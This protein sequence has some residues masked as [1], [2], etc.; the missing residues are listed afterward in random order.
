MDISTNSNNSDITNL[1]ENAEVVS[2]DIFDTLIVRPYAQP[3]DLF[4]HLE[5]LYNKKDFAERRVTAEQQARVK[6]PDKEDVTLEQIYEELGSDFSECK[7]L[8][9][10][11]EK[12]VLKAIPKTKEIFERAKSIGKRVVITS[13]VYLPREF[14]A[15]ILNDNGYTGYE[16]LYVSS[17]LML[18]KHFGT[19]FAYII[20]D[21]NVSPE[22]ILHI[23]D[24]QHADIFMAGQH[25]IKTFHCP[26]AIDLLFEANPKASIFYQVHN[27]LEASILLGLIALSYI[28]ADNA[29]A[30]SDQYGRYWHGFGYQYGG[31]VILAFTKWLDDCFKRDGIKNALFIARDGYTLQKVYDIV[32]TS[33]AASHYCYAPRRHSIGCRL[34]YADQLA[35]GESSGQDAVKAI[36]SFYKNKIDL[37]GIN[38]PNITSAEEGH[39]FIQDHIEVYKQIAVHEIQ[40]YKNYINSLLSSN[41]EIFDSTSNSHPSIGLVDSIGCFLSAQ[42]LITAAIGRGNLN[43]YYWQNTLANKDDANT[44]NLN[45]FNPTGANSFYDWNIMELIMTAPTPPIADFTGDSP[46]YKKNI[47]EEEKARI[48]VY[49]YISDGSVDFAKRAKL[50]FGDLDLFLSSNIMTDWINIFL[51][52]PS[53]E[54]MQMFETIQHAYDANHTEYAPILN[55]ALYTQEDESESAIK[56]SIIV[57]VYNSDKYL[58]FCLGSLIVQTLRDIE[59]IC[60]NDGST[61]NSQK[62]L[63]SYAQIDPRIK[64]I[65]QNNAG[66]SSARNTGMAAATGTYLAFVDSDD[67]VAIDYFEKLRTTAR[68]SGAPVACCKSIVN[69]SS[70]DGKEKPETLT[71]PLPAPGVYSMSRRLL[72]SRTIFSSSCSKLYKRSLIEK[73]NLKFPDTPTHQ[74]LYFHWC[75]LPQLSKLAVAEGTFYFSLQR[76]DSVSKKLLNASS[77][78]SLQVFDLI[79]NY[80]KDHDLLQ[81]FR[82]PFYILQESLNSCNN[83]PEF[84]AS[85]NALWQKVHSEIS[86][87]NIYNN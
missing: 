80:Y 42:K 70:G 75:L 9:L 87:A 47:S 13:D 35:A 12:Q 31:P 25:G 67:Y 21:L 69:I 83:D 86:Q 29:K 5:K 64:I 41:N 2:F 33:E 16:K 82:L 10:A 1:L 3:T 52:N 84:L 36:L 57:P 34:D 51:A 28:E 26:K 37:L 77:A 53:L 79:F 48:E 81:K 44:Y 49:P 7:D 20:K 62:I 55:P 68:L 38:T 76:E 23:G 14:L 72:E 85:A 54:D 6:R 61:D 74:D 19:L 50:H 32:K 65:V 59:I 45:A 39:D 24:N 30:T 73:L 60:V 18:T 43:G 4:I 71:C 27:N 17:Q 78:I 15:E 8:E 40:K 66:I 22:K 63:E 11:L 58:D 46:V 56:V